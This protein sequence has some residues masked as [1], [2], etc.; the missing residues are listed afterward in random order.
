M[1]GRRS[2]QRKGQALVSI[3]PSRTD[4]Y[5][6]TPHNTPPVTTLS[7]AA[8]RHIQQNHTTHRD[9]FRFRCLIDRVSRYVT[10]RI[11]DHRK[12]AQPSR[13]IRKDLRHWCFSKAVF[14]HPCIQRIGDGE[15]RWSVVQ[16][17]FKRDP[18]LWNSTYTAERATST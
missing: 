10:T 12:S 13:T 3:T 15:R 1:Y 5:S 14:D 16:E 11:G 2:E 18:W 9:G 4:T 6:R 8:G 17:F 7:H